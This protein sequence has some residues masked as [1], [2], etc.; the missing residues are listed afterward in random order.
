MSLIPPRPTLKSCERGDGELAV[1]NGLCLAHL[2]KESGALAELEE[3]YQR[4]T[5][6]DYYEPNDG[7][8]TGLDPEFMKW[9]LGGAL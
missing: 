9:M 5:S 2:Y 6:R 4:K 8:R 7:L 1:S 3:Q